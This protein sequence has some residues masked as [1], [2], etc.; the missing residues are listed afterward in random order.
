MIYT[1]TPTNDLL[2]GVHH[3]VSRDVLS[4]VVLGFLH[5]TYSD[6]R[7]RYLESSFNGVKA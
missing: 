6:P 5:G 3:M 1:P 2:V 7:R 4:D